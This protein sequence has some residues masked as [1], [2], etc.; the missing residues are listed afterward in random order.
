MNSNDREQAM[1]LNLMEELEGND[2][3]GWVISL[4]GLIAIYMCFIML[5][6]TVFFDQI[7]RDPFTL[8]SVVSMW[9]PNQKFNLHLDKKRKLES[10]RQMIKN[11]EEYAEA[12]P[13][14]IFEKK[15]NSINLPHLGSGLGQFRIIFNSIDSKKLFVTGSSNLTD[16]FKAQ[17]SSVTEYL[18]S[19]R[20]EI[21][22]VKRI[23]IRVNSNHNF[24]VSPSKS[25]LSE[26]AKCAFKIKQF[27][28]KDEGFKKYPGDY[29]ERADGLPHFAKP[30]VLSDRI[31][32]SSYVG[33]V[34]EG[35]IRQQLGSQVVI[36][37]SLDMKI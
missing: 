17:L 29:I 5:L 20:E 31:V 21:D 32:I 14:V 3:V 6:L 22:Q 10:R 12:K 11:L 16:E 30:K 33:E 19:L 9:Q 8:Q 28:D 26:T 7:Q 34:L 27:L 4:N 2:E 37:V 35:G 24:S 18:V 1:A 23:E 25:I 15:L 36:L 13:N